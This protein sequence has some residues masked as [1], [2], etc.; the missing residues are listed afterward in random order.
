LFQ[1]I[2]PQKNAGDHRK[3][4]RKIVSMD[5]EISNSARLLNHNQ[6]GGLTTTLIVLEEILCE[7]ELILA[8]DRC[9]GV[10]YEMRND[11]P[12][13]VKEEMQRRIN[14]VRERI[15]VMVEEF[16]LEKRN[17]DASRDFM[18]KLVYCWEILEGAKARHLSG[19]GAVAEE[20]A[21]TLD[22]HLNNIIILVDEM[23]DLVI[24]NKKV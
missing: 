3:G 7:I 22:P 11:L 13:Q 9:K 6:R 1:D 10:L 16:A 5:I 23:R 15:R 24:G 18:G 19:Y 21:E 20:L 4:C 17:K 8:A 14:L 2:L 12:D